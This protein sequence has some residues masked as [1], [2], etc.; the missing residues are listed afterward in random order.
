[1][2]ICFQVW[3]DD[4]RRTHWYGN[5]SLW[6]FG[7]GELKTDFGCG[8]LWILS[9]EPPGEHCVLEWE[10]EQQQR[11]NS[12]ASLSQLE[13]FVIRKEIQLTIPIVMKTETTTTMTTAVL[14]LPVADTYSYIFQSGRGMDVLSSVFFFFFL[15]DYSPWGTKP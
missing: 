2:N 6:P 8:Q 4:A 10:Q 9:A 14:F 7:P 13:N 5:S 1:M 11:C 3:T 15:R 12:Y